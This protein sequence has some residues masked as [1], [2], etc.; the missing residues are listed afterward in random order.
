MEV[1]KG[2]KIDDYRYFVHENRSTPPISACCGGSDIDEKIAPAPGANQ[3]AG[4]HWLDKSAIFNVMNNL[5]S[6]RHITFVLI[7]APCLRKFGNP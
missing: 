2:Q 5:S 3:I 6:H 4:F 1:Y 7:K